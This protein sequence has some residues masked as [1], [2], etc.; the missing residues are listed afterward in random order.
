[1]QV[2]FKTNCQCGKPQFGMALKFESGPAADYY[3]NTKNFTLKQLKELA[4][5]SR[6]MDA[7][8]DDIFVTT[9]TKGK[10]V[11]TVGQKSFK[12]NFF[13]SPIKIIK[14]AAKEAENLRKRDI[15][16]K[17]DKKEDFSQFIQEKYSAK[18]TENF[19]EE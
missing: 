16:L 13:N 18:P 9:N 3:K 17:I 5:I 15:D 4:L 7:C 1:M 6:K 12:E 14:K 10:Y 8:T 19:V 11:A 2:D